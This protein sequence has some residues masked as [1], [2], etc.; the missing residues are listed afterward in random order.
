MFTKPKILRQASIRPR[1]ILAC[2]AVSLLVSAIYVTVSYRLA[3]DVNIESERRAMSQIVSLIT[4]IP[5]SDK[6]RSPLPD[7]EVLSQIVNTDVASFIHVASTQNSISSA[8]RIDSS[9]SKQLLDI[10]A[11]RNDDDDDAIIMLDDRCFIWLRMSLGEYTITYLKETTL[12]DVTLHLV[13]KRLLITSVIVFWIA[14]W[15]ALTLSSIIAKRAE[16]VN[17]KLEK[18]ATHD[19]LTGLPN[20]LYLTEILRSIV[21]KKE[22]NNQ[23]GCLF[24]VDLDK[25]KEV[26]D[27]FGHSTG[28][29]LLIALSQRI[30]TVVQPPNELMRLGGDEFIIW[31]PD[32]TISQ[33]KVLAQELKNICDTTIPINGLEI[34]TGASVGFAHF[35]THTSSPETLLSCADSAMYKAKKQRSGWEVYDEHIV[36]SNERDVML[37]AGLNEALANNELVL[38]FQP[39]VDM[40]TGEIVSVEGLCRWQHPSL[41]LLMPYAFIDLIEHSGKVQDFG[42]YIVKQAI[43]CAASWQKEGIRI[44]IAINLSPY[45]LLDP[46]LIAFIEQ[47]LAQAQLSA[48]FIHIELTENETSLNINY[49]QEALEKIRR[50]GI[51]ISIDD[52]GTGMSSLAYLDTLKAD[53]I[54]IDRTFISD[55]E[56]NKGHRAIVSAAV[57]LAKSFECNVVAEGVETKQHADLLLSMGCYIAQ[58]YYYAKPMPEKDMKQLIETGNLP[59]ALA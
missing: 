53:T 43:Y 22:D 23:Q 27:S 48:H 28:D 25:F 9:V 54:K 5:L 17:D 36:L 56:S 38:H 30:L 32:L 51:K 12:L 58:G 57:D 19:S 16:E 46:G 39:K 15:L 21:E 37:K 20:R 45:N 40:R 34:N 42:R 11:S 7:R 13:A 52:F 59:D 31:A 33:G 50:L 10:T 44:P 18:L 1:L 6:Q 4:N 35:P 24:G 26:N 29:K 55:L 2:L 49:I 41:G 14:V 47:T 3:A 8:F